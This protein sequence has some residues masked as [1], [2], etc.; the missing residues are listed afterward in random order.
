MQSLDPS[1]AFSPDG[2]VR[3]QLGSISQTT[4]NLLREGLGGETLFILPQNLFE[5]KTNFADIEF[6]VYLNF[7]LRQGLRTRFA[8][9]AQQKL[10]VTLTAVQGK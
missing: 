10:Q 8:G 4:K 1:V 3:V 5:N 2:E 6:L 7:F 9:T